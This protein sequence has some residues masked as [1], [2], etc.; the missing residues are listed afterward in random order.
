MKMTPRTLFRFSVIAACSALVATGCVLD[1]SA[2]PPGWGQVA[3]RQYCTGD[4]LT[5]SYN[6]LGS[7]SCATSGVN[8]ADYF[9][10]V[11]LTSSPALFP[12]TSLPP[13]Y[14]GNFTFPASGDSVTVGFHSNANPV[15][16]PTDRFEG[17]SRVFLQRTGVTDVSAT[18]R[19]II[20]PQSFELT[21]TGMCDGSAH[22]YA[23]GEP[24]Q[25]PQW[26][27]NMR[28]VD[29]CN[30]NSVAINVSLS[31]GAGGTYTQMLAPGACLNT[32]A[33]G[34]PTGTDG[35]RIVNVSPLTRDPF[36]RCSAL[37]P[38]TPPATLRTVA[39]MAC[40]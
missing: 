34:V 14:T 28:M 38:N 35:A 27:P 11:T 32:T 40:R 26:S 21:H 20:G 37:G 33:P 25:P 29:V 18:A 36:A 31:G 22:A 12:S 1:R 7:D 3:P 13:G 9:P 8:C 6:F 4:T 23:P 15:T 16:I 2:I 19:R 30:T 39:H 10:T 24:A 5:A 17:G